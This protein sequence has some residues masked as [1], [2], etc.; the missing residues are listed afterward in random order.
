MGKQNNYPAKQ[1][2][3]DNFLMKN[4]KLIVLGLPVC[5]SEITI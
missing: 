5:Y 3:P 1:R 2:K 4:Y